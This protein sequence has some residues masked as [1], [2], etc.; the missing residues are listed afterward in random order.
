[1]NHI[2]LKI[3]LPIPNVKRVEGMLAIIIKKYFKEKLL[4]KILAVRA[5]KTGP[6]I[7]PI[8]KVAN[9]FP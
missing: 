7:T 6:P 8:T 3:L 1:M 2:K 9:I 5:E 4:S